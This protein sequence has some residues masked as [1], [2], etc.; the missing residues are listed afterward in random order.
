M[1][2]F[3]VLAVAGVAAAYPHARPDDPYSVPGPQYEQSYEPAPKQVY[4]ARPAYGNPKSEEYFPPQPY[5]F[6]YGVSDQ[7]TGTAFKAAENQDDAGNVLGSYEVQ[8]P[9]GRRQIVTYVANEK[10][11]FNADVKY[12]GEAQYPPEPAEGYGNTYKKSN[13][14]AP[15]PSKYAPA[16]YQ[17][18]PKPYES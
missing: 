14:Y 2:C 5:Q 4:K 12:E 7:Y 9:D 10:G 18:E 6:E 1:K 15:S 17:P 11:G 13:K 16:P 3:A 8:L